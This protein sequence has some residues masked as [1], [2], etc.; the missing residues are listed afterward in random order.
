MLMHHGHCHIRNNPY[1]L[2]AA[3]K[4]VSPHS[5][6]VHLGGLSLSLFT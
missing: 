5:I 1:A 3:M 2:L 6:V 4:L